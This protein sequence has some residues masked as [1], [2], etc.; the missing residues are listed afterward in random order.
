MWVLRYKFLESR[1][2]ARN[3]RKGFASVSNIA[4]IKKY[5][6]ADGTGVRVSVFLSGCPHH[7][8]GC[9]N[10]VA[11]SPDCGTLFTEKTITEII[12]ALNKPYISGV[13]ILGGEPLV[14]YN[15]RITWQIAYRTKLIGKTVWIYSGYTYE[16]LAK[17]AKTNE[18][19]RKSLHWTDVLVDGRFVNSLADKRLAFR[20]SSNQRI[21]DMPA[22]LESG[23]VVL[24]HQNINK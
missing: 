1:T 16:E 19:V 9:F 15:A 8:D 23:H 14:D 18:D 13:S 2:N 17:T 20:G 4:E 21:I 5:D 11:W 22:T 10:A 3:P 12:D 24:W 7:C 6:V